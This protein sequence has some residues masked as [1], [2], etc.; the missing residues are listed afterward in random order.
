M[1]IPSDEEDTEDDCD[2]GEFDFGRK[3]KSRFSDDCACE[4]LDRIELSDVVD[5]NDG[6]YNMDG[7]AVLSAEHAAAQSSQG[8]KVY[9]QPDV[10]EKT[11]GVN[12]AWNKEKKE[13]D[14]DYSG[15]R[16]KTFDIKG[17]ISIDERVEGG[18]NKLEETCESDTGA[19][20]SEQL[21]QWGDNT[22]YAPKVC[23]SSSAGSCDCC[24]SKCE[25]EY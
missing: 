19:H 3:I 7:Q 9:A 6:R 17:S 25:E 20:D 5:E 10:Y 24:D 23:S 13:T 11:N 4:K 12:N 8:E 16:R 18:I 15:C 2:F 1:Y 21:T 22:A 14:E